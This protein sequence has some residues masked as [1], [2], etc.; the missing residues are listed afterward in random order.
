MDAE[1]PEGTFVLW[2]DYTKTGLD[3][4]ALEKLLDKACFLGDW[5]EEYYGHPLAM[6][7][8]LALPYGEIQDTMVQLKQSARE[9]A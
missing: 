3:K 1:V 5:G 6:R 8:S 4:P 9:M 2:V 7:Y